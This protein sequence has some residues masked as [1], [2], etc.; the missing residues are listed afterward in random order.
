LGEREITIPAGTQPNESIILKSEGI[1][2][3]NGRGKGDLILKVKVSLPKKITK[4]QKELLEEFKKE[5]EKG[6]FSKI[7]H[8]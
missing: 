6:F 3:R 4:R 2:R 8:S 7:I 1:P 5:N